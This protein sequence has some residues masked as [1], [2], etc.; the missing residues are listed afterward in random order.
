MRNVRYD[1]PIS[2]VPLYLYLST[3]SSA[4][5]L[6]ANTVNWNNSW[7]KSLPKAAVL[8][9]LLYIFA[10]FAKKKIKDT[11]EFVP[12][13]PVNFQQQLQNLYLGMYHPEV[14]HSGQN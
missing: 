6:V 1:I 9:F 7:F 10:K 14:Q 11:V 12:R 2:P 13:T 4:T 5:S 3:S 8:K